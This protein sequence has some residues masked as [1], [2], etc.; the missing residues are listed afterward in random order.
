V[1]LY[2]TL[3]VMDRVGWNFIKLNGF[4]WDTDADIMVSQQQTITSIF[5]NGVT[6]LHDKQYLTSGHNFE[7][8]LE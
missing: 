1:N 2:D 4:D 7:I 5:K 8:I 3:N 6:L